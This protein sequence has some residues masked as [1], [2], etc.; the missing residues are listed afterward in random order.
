M[1][2]GHDVFRETE[3]LQ[4]ALSQNRKPLGFMIS[5]GRPLSIRVNL[6]EETGDSC[7]GTGR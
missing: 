5:A 6:R 7:R 3:Y 1:P 4:Q 2:D